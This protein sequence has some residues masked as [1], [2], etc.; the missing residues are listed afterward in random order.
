VA[1]SLCRI[2][3]PNGAGI[4][5]SYHDETTIKPWFSTTPHPP[6]R[7]ARAQNAGSGRDSR[8]SL[9]PTARSPQRPPRFSAECLV[10]YVVPNRAPGGEHLDETRRY[11]RL[12]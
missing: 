11:D 2:L 7:R 9:I 3:R 12:K 10:V 8:S 6:G 1:R 5:G 4:C